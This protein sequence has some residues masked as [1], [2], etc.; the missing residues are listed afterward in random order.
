MLKESNRALRNCPQAEFAWVYKAHA[1]RLL[2]F[3]DEAA[4]A[5]RRVEALAQERGVQLR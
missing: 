3:H 1:L 4:E 5:D 2:G